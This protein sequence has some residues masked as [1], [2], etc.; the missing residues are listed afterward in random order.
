MKRVATLCG[1]LLLLLV[2]AG[3]GIP[4]DGQEP[5]FFRDDPLQ[6]EPETQDASQVQEWEINLSADLLLNL[7]GMPGDPVAN[8]RAQNV[9]TADEVPDSSWFTNRIHTRAISIDEVKR[10][11][12]TMAGPA[13]GRWTVIGAKSAGVAPGFTVRDE[14]GE[15]WFVTFDGRD[16]PIAP[17][18]AIAVASRLFWALGYNQIETYLSSV[19]PENLIV[20]E[21]VTI[22][23]HGER[24]PFTQADLDEVLARSAK[25]ADGSYRLIAGRA[26][27]GRPLGGFRYHGTRPDDPNDIVPHEHRRELRAL[28]VFGAWTNLV[29]MKAGNT[30]DTLI[31]E[32]GRGIV[33]HYL[34][35]VGSTFG[36]GA[37]APRDGDEGY[38][39]LYEQ[40]PFVKRLVTMGLFIS[41]WQTVDYE[42]HPEVGKFEGRQFDP[43]TWKPRV[44]V[45][46]LR[47]VRHDDALWAALRVMAFSDEQI[48]A[49]VSVGD[50]TDPA[51]AKLLGDV[52]IQRRHR[53]G[54]VYF[55]AINPLTGFVLTDAGGLDFENPAVR[56]GFAK[57]PE[58]GYE[59]S[60]FRFNNATGQSDSQG[61]PTTSIAGPFP[62]PAALPRVDDAFVRVSIRAIEPDHAAWRVPVEVYFRR[63]GENW[64]LVGVERM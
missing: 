14:S 61:P 18:A 63:S 15:V 34:Q 38:E 37:L 42:E 31:S 10:G 4:L 7:F 1:I 49:A 26:V 21:G 27:P 25:S 60:W 32:N 44:P 57:A 20:G 43:M 33:R 28:Q 12:N 56:A 5:R 40:G 54:Q 36:T 24:R 47:H 22:R 41:P 8:Q 2:S 39:Y 58:K 52:L 45:A 50:F 51:A 3:P 11:P 48:R 23:A 62:P 46:A 19:R 16:N 55:A 30:L 17:T 35:D 6:R 64:T 13:P 29:D 53:I 59:I 9:N